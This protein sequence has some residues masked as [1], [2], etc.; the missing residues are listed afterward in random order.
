MIRQKR[1]ASGYSKAFTISS[2]IR[3]QSSKIGRSTLQPISFR[4]ILENGMS[5]FKSDRHTLNSI[6]S[7]RHTVQSGQIE[8]NKMLPKPHCNN[9]VPVVSPTDMDNRRS[10]RN[11]SDWRNIVLSKRNLAA[12]ALRSGV[13]GAGWS[14]EMGPFHQEV[15][16]FSVRTATRYARNAF[17]FWPER[18]APRSGCR[19][20]LSGTDAG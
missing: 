2:G 11:R 4:H 19:P 7:S 10:V 20:S 1:Y 15:M 3:R 12:K 5:I 14:S 16:S 6:S 17:H 18:I 9:Q 13:T 8:Q